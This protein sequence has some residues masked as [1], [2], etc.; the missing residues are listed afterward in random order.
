[1][2]QRANIIADIKLR[3]DRPTDVS[4]RDL[5]CWTVWQFPRRHSGGL[6]GAIHPPIAKHGWFPVVIRTKDK[7]VQIHA[8]LGQAF[9]SPEAAAK[10]LFKRAR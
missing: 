7:R 4:L 9:P 2:S 8:H 1:M 10:Y 3:T 5:Y 6:C